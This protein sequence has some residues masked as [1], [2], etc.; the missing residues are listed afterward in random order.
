MVA[1]L[2]ASPEVSVIVA[3]LR[4][5]AD[6]GIEDARLRAPIVT[7]GALSRDAKALAADQVFL[8]LGTTIKKAGSRLA[9]RAVDHD[10][11]LEAARVAASAG[12]RD[13][14]LVSSLGAD[15][16]ARGFYLRVKGEV[17]AALSELPFRSLHVF[18][19]SILTGA[20]SGIPPRRAG[21]DPARQPP[22]SAHGGTAAPLPSHPGRRRRAG[23]GARIARPGRRSNRPRI[24]GDR[25]PRSVRGAGIPPY[26]LGWYLRWTSRRYSRSTC[27]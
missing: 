22:G 25:R 21:G 15:P 13:A 9:F 2:A 26:A 18:R 14:F 23:H 27:V 12:A 20:P 8:C 11:I 10:A 24:R 19:P 3:P 17:E 16:T 7:F 4:R 1:E 6:L 5:A